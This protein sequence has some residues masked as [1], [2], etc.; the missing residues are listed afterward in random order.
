MFEEY[1]REIIKFTW[2]MLYHQ[3]L[4]SVRWED[5]PLPSD[6]SSEHNLSDTIRPSSTIESIFKNG[7]KLNPPVKDF[8]SE[9]SF[10]S[11]RPIKYKPRTKL[12]AVK[13]RPLMPTTDR[14]IHLGRGKSQAP[15]RVMNR[16][17]MLFDESRRLFMQSEPNP[18]KR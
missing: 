15:Q 17:E 7:S 3:N 12:S 9:K 1:P 13:H 4:I 8:N 6:D 2:N 5:A 18:S 14:I 10:N 16:K 11:S